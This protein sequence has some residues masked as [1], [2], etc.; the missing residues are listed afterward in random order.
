MAG[1]PADGPAHMKFDDDLPPADELNR[2]AEALMARID[3]HLERRG[4][5]SA[6][7]SVVTSDEPAGQAPSS[8]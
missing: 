8:E 4:P 5:P 6:D 2:R 3:K 1:N 7:T